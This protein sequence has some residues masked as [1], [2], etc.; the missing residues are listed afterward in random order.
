MKY[1]VAFHTRRAARR[2]TRAYDNVLR[3]YGLRSTQF[4]LLSAIRHMLYGSISALGDWAGMERSTLLRNLRVLEKDGLIAL[5]PE[6]GN[7]SRSVKITVA[8][9]VLLDEAT[10]QWQA[11]QKQLVDA[12]GAEHWQQVR[13]SLEALPDEL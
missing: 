6:G 11:M 8:G 9:E 10:P 13:K 2:L 12:M 3:P 4:S 7:R 1:C 5:G